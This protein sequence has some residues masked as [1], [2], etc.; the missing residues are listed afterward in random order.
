M[1]RRLV[2]ANLLLITIVLVLLELPLAIVYSRHEHDALQTALQRDGASLATFA[3]ETIEGGGHHDIGDLARRYS[4]RVGGA[5][6]VVDRTGKE[7][8]PPATIA[9]DAAVRAALREATA[10]GVRS[11]EVHGLSYVAAPIGG[12]TDRHGAV[13]VAR[14]DGAVDRRVHRFWTLLVGVGLA[15][16]AAAI[17]I[18]RRLAAW[19]VGPLQELDDAAAALGRGELA[20]RARTR[21]GPPEVVM[22]AETFND[23]AARLDELVA[24]QRRFVADASHQLR[25]PLTALRLRLE[26]L[27]AD[28]PQALAATR[29]AALREAARLTR[30]V[31]GL[32]A[33]AR[34]EGRRPERQV[35][36]VTAIVAERHEAWAPLAA[37]HDIDLRVEGN[38][39]GAVTA[40]AVP[41]HLEQIL[42]NLIDNAIDVT[43]AGGGVRLRAANAETAVE[44]HVADDGPGLTPEE[45]QRAFDAF[46]QRSRPQSNGGGTG[47]GLAI[48]DQLVRACHGRVTLEAAPGGGIDATISLPR[49]STAARAT[50]T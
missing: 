1:N 3:E 45:R 41:G 14:D 4:A 7:L 22:L 47:L 25:T 30:L 6:V 21:P 49:A 10:G 40:M 32:L 48:V 13:L 29:D 16:L 2:L 42:D 46:W 5:V 9:A 43:P 12:G 31:D 8:T 18:S 11:G 17:L 15:V 37:E 24:S 38:G 20:A 26:N 36:D 39:L 50:T 34:A 19:A 23:M 44:V 35:I 27:D 33:L 28:D